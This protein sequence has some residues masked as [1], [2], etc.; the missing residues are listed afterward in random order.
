MEAGAHS[1]RPRSGG[2]PWNRGAMCGSGFSRSLIRP[3]HTPLPPSSHTQKNA[4]SGEKKKKR[5]RKH[6]ELVLIK[7]RAAVSPLPASSL[8]LRRDMAVQFSG[9]HAVKKTPR[10]ADVRF[11]FSTPST[12]LC[13]A[14]LCAT[15]RERAHRAGAQR[16]S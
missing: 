4:S 10:S 7:T 9:F 8:S 11:F 3:H 1:C 15:R 16:R 14:F 13:V 2:E 5:E 12:F 6:V